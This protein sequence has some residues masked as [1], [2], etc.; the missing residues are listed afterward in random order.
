MTFPA[1][2]VIDDT[3]KVAERKTPD[4]GEV[5]PALAGAVVVGSLLGGRIGARLQHR[6]PQRA[7]VL[8]FVGVAAF[9]AFQMLLRAFGSGA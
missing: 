5:E 8:I 6:L 3:P 9:F 4:R 1:T 7:L 2:T